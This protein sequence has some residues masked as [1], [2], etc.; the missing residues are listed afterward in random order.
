MP[1]GKFEFHYFLEREL[2]FVRLKI[3]QLK[4]VFFY[5][6]YCLWG[7]SHKSSPLGH[8]QMNWLQPFATNEFGASSAS[9]VR[10]FK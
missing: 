6:E 9:C 8:N 5:H 2:C 4:L 7:R 1:L 10:R 3:Q